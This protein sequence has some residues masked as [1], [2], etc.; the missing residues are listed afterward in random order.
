MAYYDENGTITIDENAANSDCNRIEKAIASLNDSKKALQNLIKQAADGKGQTAMAVAEKGAELTGK[1]TDM[2]SRL[3][4]T[5]T[6]INK[7]VQHYQQVDA[8]VKA[9]I[10]NADMGGVIN[11]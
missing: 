8:A 3:E 11:G 6:F 10:A 9:S 5:R 7:T 4:E 2:I 1:I